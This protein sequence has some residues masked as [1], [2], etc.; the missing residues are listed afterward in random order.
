MKDSC[1]N[2]IIKFFI[3]KIFIGVIGFFSM[4]LYS[5]LLDP[6]EYGNYSLIIGFINILIAI[7]I[8][9]I[10]SSALRYYDENRNNKT[11]FFSNITISIF[12]MIFVSIIITYLGTIFFKNIPL[13]EYFIFVIFLLSILSCVD[14][15]EKVLR[16]SKETNI[17]MYTILLQTFLN[18]VVFYILIK[19]YNLGI[20]ALFISNIISNFI[21][22]LICIFKLKI[23]KNL[24]FKKFDREL[25]KRFLEYGIPMIGV[26]G[27]GWILSYCDRY[28]IAMFYSSYDVGI[29]DMSYKIAENSINILIT[30]FTLAVFPR[31]ISIWNKHGEQ[32]TI[33]KLEEILRY[34]FIL[35]IPAIIGLI[36][37]SDKLY[38]TILDPS[39]SIGKNIIII[40]SIG[41][42]FNG[43]CNILNKVWQLNKSTKNIFYIMFFSAVINILLNILLLPK[44]G[45]NVAAYTTLISYFTGNI[46]TYILIRNK[47]KLRIDYKSI[48]ISFISCIPMSVYIYSA[49]IS[50]IIE[51]IIQILIAIV[52]YIVSSVICGNLKSE[53]KYIIN[54]RKLNE[55]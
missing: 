29:Y 25:Q 55:I 38:I 34:Y 39:Y 6:S 23:Y 8:G 36:S 11:I 42:L 7:F 30:S 12:F 45:I 31:L 16:A 22:L 44:F 3:V 41:M 48:L 2:D 46:V 47:F 4:S 40:T 5:S 1:N 20:Y 24:E 10:G 51:L 27:I 17:Y 18:I 19:M 50:N 43:L 54:R 26:W 28:M 15:F 52:I 14:V 49:N 35:I 21:F 37:I 32:K 9:W 13:K 53:V 33:S